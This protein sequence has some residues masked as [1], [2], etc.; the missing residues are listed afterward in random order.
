MAD[1]TEQG[2]ELTEAQK[3]ALQS[4]ISRA[5]MVRELLS[6]PGM[7][8]LKEVIED[9]V[10]RAQRNWLSAKTP[11][12]AEAVRVQAQGIQNF[13]KVA[14]VVLLRG[15]A[16]SKQLASNKGENNTPSK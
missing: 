3:S 1:V 13:F 16:A 9:L 11:Q 14:E 7:T 15:E 8:I 6:H 12:D 10:G 2:V 5:A 4:A